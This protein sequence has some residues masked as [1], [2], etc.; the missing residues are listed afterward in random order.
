[1][2]QPLNG[3]TLCQADNQLCLTSYLNNADGEF[4]IVYTNSIHDYLS[5]TGP[6]SRIG[7]IRSTANGVLRCFSNQGVSCSSPPDSQ[8]VPEAVPLFFGLNSVSLQTELA[9]E[10][11][12][13]SPMQPIQGAVSP[14]N[15]QYLQFGVNTMDYSSCAQTYSATVSALVYGV[16]VSGVQFGGN[17]GTHDA[18]VI[19]EYELGPTASQNHVERYFY[20]QGLGRVREASATY[21]I[22]DGLY[23]ASPHFNS[24][25]NMIENNTITIPPEE[26]PQGSTTPLQS[27]RR[28]L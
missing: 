21:D 22:N 10:N 16:Y 17:V 1:M 19:D 6:Y 11:S 14:S 18:V 8:T 13:G 25:R 2:I 23:D 7:V 12:D 9:S 27:I 15:G 24:V 4:E 26:C 20:V 5:V 3:S 28:R